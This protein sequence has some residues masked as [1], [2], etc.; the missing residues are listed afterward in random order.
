[1]E[2]EFQGITIISCDLFQIHEFISLSLFLLFN[3]SIMRG[4]ERRGEERRGEERR[5]EER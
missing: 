5:G 4:E 3:I 1:M 2:S